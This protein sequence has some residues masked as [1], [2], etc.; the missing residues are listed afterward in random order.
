MLNEERIKELLSEAE[1]LP[2]V[3]ASYWGPT[4]K[5]KVVKWLIGGLTIPGIGYTEVGAISQPLSIVMA[6][7]FIR[8]GIAIESA[9]AITT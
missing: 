4:I 9:P 1:S 3:R 2:A 7:D 8:Q 5:T 6:D